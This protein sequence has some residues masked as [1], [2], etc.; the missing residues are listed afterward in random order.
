MTVS[1]KN[2]KA[3]RI[4][5]DPE[6]GREALSGSGDL[7]GYG[8]ICEQPIEFGDN[9]LDYSEN[10]SAS[11]LYTCVI[12]KGR[13]WKKSPIEGL[14]AYVDIKSVNGGR[15]PVQSGCGE[16]LW[17]EPVC[18]VWGDDRTIKTLPPEKERRAV[19]ERVTKRKI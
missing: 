7:A 13:A 9:L 2:C 12:P 18:W 16:H 1:G 5:P 8:K 10:V 6:S 3:G 14:E 15:L 11:E 4:S 17:V 19:V